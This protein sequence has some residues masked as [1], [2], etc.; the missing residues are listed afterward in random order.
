[1]I[2]FEKLCKL[3]LM[4]EPFY[5]IVL[6]SFNK[7]ASKDIDTL[8]VRQDGNS[9][10]LTYNPDFLN[11][12]N[13]NTCLELLKH[14]MMHICFNH[15]FM[16]AE[17]GYDKED[18]STFNIACDLECNC[19]LNRSR[20]MPEVGGIWAE[21]YGFAKELGAVTYYAK[22]RQN[23]PKFQQQCQ[24][25]GN[26]QGQGNDDGSGN[27][28][29][30]DQGQ[31][32]NSG[33]SG[34]NQSTKDNSYPSF[35]NHENWPKMT[36]MQA[37]R[38]RHM[39]ENIILSAAESVEKSYGTD[40]IPE[41]MRIRIDKLRKKTRPVADWRRYCRRFMGNEYSWMTKKSRRR[42]SKRFEGMMGTRHM[43]KSKILVAIDTSG[44]VS[45][46]EYKEFMR[47]VL[48]MKNVVDFDVVECDT[49]IRYEYHFAGKPNTELH[50][51]GG[52]SFQQPVDLFYQR[53]FYDAL[54][55]FTD[56]EC[57]IPDNTPKDTLWIISS[58]GQKENDYRKNGAKVIFIPKK[59]ND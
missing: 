39:M 48:T 10:R 9:F 54:I 14:D 37:E 58:K 33:G 32:Q 51:G 55:Y 16:G 18:H 27:G 35:D 17:T 12:F 21:D 28:G 43:R 50:G 38:A 52:T 11:R 13:E 40:S 34:Q 19:Y 8:G 56:G 57:P 3:F 46:P 53:G 59:N 45:M 44:S 25:N 31:G 36:K 30:Y 49:M 29:N 42:E 23:S 1:M 20:M 7:E 22:V 41:P 6:S 24:G 2:D 26:G 4:E 15:I 5:G 47:Q